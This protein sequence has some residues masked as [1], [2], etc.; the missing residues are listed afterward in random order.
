MYRFMAAGTE[1]NQA[2]QEIKLFPDNA[3]AFYEVC[4][5]VNFQINRRTANTAFMPV[6]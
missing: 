1:G 2:V 5:M 4:Q 3:F 6:P